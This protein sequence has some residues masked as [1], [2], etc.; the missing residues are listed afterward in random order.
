M[1]EGRRIFAASDRGIIRWYALQALLGTLILK[2]IYQY[3]K[4]VSSM[5]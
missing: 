3:E 4:N 5:R 2:S 1:G